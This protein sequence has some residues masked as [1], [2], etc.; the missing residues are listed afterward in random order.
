MVPVDREGE[1]LCESV[2]E[3]E[4]VS[5]RGGRKGERGERKINT[6]TAPYQKSEDHTT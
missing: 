4:R 2:R 1:S 6:F 5:D 3:C